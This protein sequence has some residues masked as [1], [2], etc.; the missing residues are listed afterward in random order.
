MISALPDWQGRIWFAAKAGV[1]GWTDRDGRLRSRDLGERISNSFA[2]GQGGG[3]FVV[4]DAAMYRL[5]AGEASRG[6]SGARLREHGRP[7]A[8]TDEPRLGDDADPA[9][10]PLRG[11]HRQRRPDRGRRHGPRPQAGQAAR[12]LPEPVLGKGTGST[13][14]SLIGIGR[15][16]AVENNF[17]YEGPVSVRARAARPA[18][19]ERVDVKPRRG[20]SGGRAATAGPAGAATR[21]LP[22]WCPSSRSPTG[23]STPTRSPR[24]RRRRPLVPDRD[25]LPQR[26]RP[27]YKRLAGYGL[28]FNNNYAPV[29]LGPDGTAYVGVLGG[30]VRIERPLSLLKER[31]PA[32]PIGE[33]MGL[34]S[35]QSD[36]LESQLV[37]ARKRI[38]ELE[39]E[40]SRPR[41]R[42]QL[43]E[44]LLT[45]RAF[46]A[47]LELDVQRAHRYRRPLSVAMIDVDGFRAI[48]LNHGYGAG[49]SVL[50]AVAD[51]DLGDDPGS[52][53]RLPD[54]R[55]RVRDPAARDRLAGRP[56]GRRA[57]PDR[58][59]G[60]L[61]RAGPRGQRLDR[62]RRAAPEADARAAALLRQ[63]ALEQARAGGGG[64]ARLLERRRRARRWPRPEA[65]AR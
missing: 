53:S 19:I 44:S 58:A 54:G 39:G 4:T 37:E 35:K 18:G 61:G 3:V 40:L 41:R 12:R 38:A 43:T 25:R 13:D 9:E 23:S 1:V 11:D 27:V 16:I 47:Q 57:H 29:T 60:P 33:P 64:R 7:E 26:P 34:L 14:Q 20:R 28:G 45:L 2:V 10:P 6:W 22:R 21:S 42:D 49:D 56:P 48:N 15:S 63:K 50:V 8:R 55:R 17:G 30:L 65:G 59:R 24:R 5:E 31:S 32:P 51:G 52:R 36:V 62:D 46:R